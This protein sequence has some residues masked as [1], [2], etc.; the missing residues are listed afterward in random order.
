[1]KDNNKKKFN[2]LEKKKFPTWVEK[3]FVISKIKTFKDPNNIFL[4]LN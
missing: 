4:S 3:T 1:M 2:G